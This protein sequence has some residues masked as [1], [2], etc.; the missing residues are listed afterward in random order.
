M[1]NEITSYI[2]WISEHKN[3]KNNKIADKAAK[4]DAKQSNLS[5]TERFTFINY[6]KHRIKVKALKN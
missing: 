1:N 2:H 4:S 5:D 6:V 3:I